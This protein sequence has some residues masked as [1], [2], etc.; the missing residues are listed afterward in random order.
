MIRSRRGQML[1]LFQSYTYY[2]RSRTRQGWRWDC[3]THNSKDCR[4]KIYTNEENDITEITG[5]HTH[6]PPK[7]H[8]T[9]KVQPIQLTNGRMLLML[10]GYT[11][12]CARKLKDRQRW[13]CSSSSGRKCRVVIYVT[14]QYQLLH[15]SNEHLHEPPIYVQTEQGFYV[16]A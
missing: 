7:F 5:N 15:I 16:K 14:N 6:E 9:S 8:I 3:S 11:F 4:A 10:N 1:M 12:W 2:K 13:V